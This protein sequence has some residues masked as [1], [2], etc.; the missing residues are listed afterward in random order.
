MVNSDRARIARTLF[1]ASV[2]AAGLGLAGCV[3]SPTYGTDKTAN[4]QLIEDITGMLA[5]G[6]K[7]GP[8]I[9]YKPRPELVTPETTAVLPPPQDDV[10]TAS[11]Q[12]WPESPEQRLARI[13][14]E[15]DE[16]RDSP[17]FRP[18]VVND[19]T[20]RNTEVT[21][22]DPILSTMSS[23]E[24]REELRRRRVEM[25]GGNASGRQYLSEP[26]IVYRQ[27]APTAPTDDLGEP[28]WRKD[29]RA[30]RDS[31]TASNDDTSPNANRSTVP[32]G[33]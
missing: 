9:D 32:T 8:G 19:A 14:A 20:E 26:P 28:E 29:R 18:N 13:R 3:A 5:L 1:V 30:R 27:P 11:N 16:N 6:P 2:A 24:Q 7:R 10:T 22:D 4:E 12:A 15:A 21:Y 25:N 17:F 33:L 31:R 23:R